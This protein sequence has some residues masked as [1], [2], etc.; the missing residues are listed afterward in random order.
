MRERVKIGRRTRKIKIGSRSQ[1]INWANRVQRSGPQ[2]PLCRGCR[3]T[4]IDP[5]TGGIYST[6]KARP[7]RACNGKGERLC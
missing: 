2:G 3:G 6:V 4:G 1:K 5:E 7:H